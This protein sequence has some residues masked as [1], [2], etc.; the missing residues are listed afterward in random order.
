MTLTVTIPTMLLTG[1]LP[2]QRTRLPGEEQARGP[3][4][5]RT[6]GPVALPLTG[7]PSGAGKSPRTPILVPLFHPP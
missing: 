4:A 7:F 1:P 6:G 3:A 2:Q 5:P